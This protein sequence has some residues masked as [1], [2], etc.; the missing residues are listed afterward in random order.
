M[1][2]SLG[3]VDPLRVVDSFMVIVTIANIILIICLIGVT[4]WR[5][6]TE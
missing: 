3:T 4:V 5:T 6:V 2:W 1:T